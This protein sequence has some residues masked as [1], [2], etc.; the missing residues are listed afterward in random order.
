[1]QA[2]WDKRGSWALINRDKP[3]HVCPGKT[4]WWR[5]Q[6]KRGTMLAIDGSYHLKVSMIAI[7]LPC[8]VS[9]SHSKTAPAGKGRGAEVFRYLK[10]PNRQELL[11]PDLHLLVQ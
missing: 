5:K 1:M 8:P 9:M 3:L 6:N 7:V 2:V 4:G 11:M 10:S